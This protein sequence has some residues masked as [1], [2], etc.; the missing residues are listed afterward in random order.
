MK[1]NYILCLLMALSITHHMLPA[2]PV[3]PE[4]S[5]EVTTA[6]Q[7]KQGLSDT[8]LAT[9]PLTPLLINYGWCE[10]NRWLSTPKTIGVDIASLIAILSL[11]Q[12]YAQHKKQKK[13]RTL[14]YYAGCAAG[15]GALGALLAYKSWSCDEEAFSVFVKATLGTII[16]RTTGALVRPLLKKTNLSP[17]VHLSIELLKCIFID[18]R[19]TRALLQKILASNIQLDHKFLVKKYFDVKPEASDVQPTPTPA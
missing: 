13:L 5:V 7:V 4:E 2:D 17:E 16:A 12:E 14:S 15:L 10:Y 3:M 18:S 9:F 8:L 1:R 19:I 6:M 11:Q